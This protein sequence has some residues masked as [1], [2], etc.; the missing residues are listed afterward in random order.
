MRV[1]TNTGDARQ[2]ESL[3]GAND[4]DNAYTKEMNTYKYVRIYTHPAAGPAFRRTLAQILSRC[5]RAPGIEL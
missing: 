2:G 1:A 4:M 3:F 5:P